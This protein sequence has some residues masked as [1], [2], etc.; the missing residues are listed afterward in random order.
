MAPAAAI[1]FGFICCFERLFIPNN[2]NLPDGIPTLKKRRADF[3]W[4]R[5][6]KWVA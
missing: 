2:A 5:M 4:K 6:G 3:V 1:F